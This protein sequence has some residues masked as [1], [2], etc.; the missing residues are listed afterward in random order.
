MVQK[1]SI[2]HAELALKAYPVAIVFSRDR[3]LCHKVLHVLSDIP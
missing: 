2:V 1:K 3:E